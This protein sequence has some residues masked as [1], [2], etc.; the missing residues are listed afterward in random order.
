MEERKGNKVCV[1]MWGR[2]P[3]LWDQCLFLQRI[4][5]EGQTDCGLHECRTKPCGPFFGQ[6]ASTGSVNHP[7]IYWKAQC[8]HSS[9]E[10]LV[11]CNPPRRRKRKKCLP[12]NVSMGTYRVY[13]NTAAGHGGPVLVGHGVVKANAER[14]MEQRESATA[15]NGRLERRE[16]LSFG[17]IR[18]SCDW[19]GHEALGGQ[20][21]QTLREPNIGSQVTPS[22]LSGVKDKKIISLGLSAGECRMGGSKG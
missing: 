10:S 21:E 18:H 5:F 14:G 2:D 7:C 16:R 6:K 22:S 13:I 19:R 20:T 17:Q 12:L 3:R 4:C 11:N 8:L 1:Y 9:G 15:G